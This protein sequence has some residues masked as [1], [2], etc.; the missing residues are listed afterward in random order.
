MKTRVIK[1]DLNPEW[2]EELSLAIPKP[3]LPLKLIVFD[4]DM[5]SADDKMGDAEI[6]LHPLVAAAKLQQGV[7]SFR[8]GM[9]I[10]QIVATDE[11]GFVNDSVIKF[12]NGHIVQVVSINLKNVEKG[13]IELE[14]KWQPRESPSCQ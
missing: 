4:K 9:T 5:F 2:N 3:L 10:Q 12:K 11:N 6:D 14:L 13:Q 7:Q 1:R 8:E